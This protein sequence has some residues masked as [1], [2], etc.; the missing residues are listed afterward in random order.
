MGDNLCLVCLQDCLTRRKTLQDYSCNCNYYVHTDC[1]K[2]WKDFTGNRLCLICEVEA[3][4]NQEI[5][6]KKEFNLFQA[7]LYF[8]LIYFGLLLI[9]LITT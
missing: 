3:S 9:V 6:V 2:K 8:L 5:T 4:V 1:Y 7:L